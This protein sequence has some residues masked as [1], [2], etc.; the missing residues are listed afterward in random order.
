MDAETFKPS[1]KYLAKLRM[2][3]SIIAAGFLLGAFFLTLLLIFG[4]GI[5]AGLIT[6]FIIFALDLLW[7]IPAMVL[8]GPYYRSL[9]YEIHEDE[10]ILHVG[11]WTKSVKHVP[12]RTVT[13]L[14]V[15][16]GILD[17][18]L[19]LGTLDI[20]TAGASGTTSAEQ[21]LV[22]LA[23]PQ[24]VYERVVAELRRFRG[25]MAPTAAEEE[26]VVS[27]SHAT[28]DAILNE[29]QAIRTMLEKET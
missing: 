1:P 28:L 15:N 5:G 7:W 10:I 2:Q 27:E 17:R 13:N 4:E 12:Y 16:R 14:T 23:T 8:A 25:G 22:G 19:S 20:Q 3:I 21:S 26:A 9:R 11:I 29:V 18:W 6:F 24:E